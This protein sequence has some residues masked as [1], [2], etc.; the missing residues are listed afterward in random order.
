MKKLI[1]FFCI[2]LT[3]SLQAQ[4]CNCT[5]NFK[6][7]KKTFEENDA[8]FSLVISK[9]GNSEYE[10]LNKETLA[11]I[12]DITDKDKCAESIVSWLKFFRKAHFSFNVNENET[13]ASQGEAPKLAVRNDWEKFAITDKQLEKYVAKIDGTTPEGIWTMA[14]Y[15]VAIVKKENGYVGFIVDGGGTPWQKKQI[16]LRFS[17]N[18][19]TNVYKGVIYLRNYFEYKF[20][21]AELIGYNHL[22]L[23]KGFLFNRKDIKKQDSEVLNKYLNLISTNGAA[24]KKY[25]ETTMYMRIPSFESNQKEIIDSIID[26]N[27]GAITATKNLII[28]LRGN[29][30]GS[31]SSYNNIIPLLYTNPIR[32]IPTEFLST[33]LNNRRYEEWL[34]EEGLLEQDKKVLTERLKKLNDNLGKFVGMYDDKVFVQR[35][36]TIYRYPENVAILI[37]GSNGSTAEQFLLAAK[38]SRKVK[39]YGTTT[40]GVLDISNMYFVNSPDGNFELGYCLSKSRRI[41]YMAI[42]DKGIQPDFYM[43]ADIPQYEWIDFA[44]KIMNNQ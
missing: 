10:R 44:E 24:L 33:P 35:E 9:K 19:K 39:L 8:G 28:D 25:S 34:K 38:Q 23:D 31:D 12:A 26:A 18:E 29:G 1:I 36:D 2:G 41:P 43:D 7:V 16:K 27:K 15:T 37:N 17:I 14:P 5:E 11:Q 22:L 6:W 42:D 13:T 21:K 20:D 30:G 4:E 3:F 32:I 40:M